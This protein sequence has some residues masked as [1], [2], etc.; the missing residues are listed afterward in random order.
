[1]NR[2]RG[3]PSGA[4]PRATSSQIDEM[5]RAGA[6]CEIE[7]AEPGLRARVVRAA[8][9]LQHESPTALSIDHHG[10]W[11]PWRRAAVALAAML[12][13][14]VMI[15]VLLGPRRQSAP[16][17]LPTGREPI[18][19]R[20]IAADPARLKLTLL[21]TTA[22]AEQP[23]REEARRLRGDIERGVKFLRS[24]LSLAKTR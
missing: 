5:L 24:S 6:P 19:A 1:M 23:L 14:G 21:R 22:D 2:D 13:L 3:T 9:R 10:L 4:R 16:P 12:I 20:A 11:W 8:A 17:M 7:H 15:G 18:I